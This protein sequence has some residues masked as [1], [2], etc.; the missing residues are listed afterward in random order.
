MDGA[1][2]D[3]HHVEIHRDLEHHGAAGRDHNILCVKRVSTLKKRETGIVGQS[4]LRS[5]T[6]Q[7]GLRILRQRGRLVPPFPRVKTTSHPQAGD[8]SR[9]EMPE[10]PSAVAWQ[11]PH[12]PKLVLTSI[13]AG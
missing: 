4:C 12:S 8:V 1:T 11:S 7:I 9:I 10:A 2:A 5:N 6:A 3:D 13:T